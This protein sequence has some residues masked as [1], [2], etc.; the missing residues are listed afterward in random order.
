MNE[1]DKKLYELALKQ[2]EER[3]GSP[4][5]HEVVRGGRCVKCLRKVGG[6]GYRL[7]LRHL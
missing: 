3:F 2:G 5:E 1:V 6:C 4:C 7:T